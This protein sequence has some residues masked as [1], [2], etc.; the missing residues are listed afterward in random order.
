MQKNLQ[1]FID[2]GEVTIDD[3]TIKKLRASGIEVM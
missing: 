2:V 3:K 1:E